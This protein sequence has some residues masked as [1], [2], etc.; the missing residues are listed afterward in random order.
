MAFG[1]K[2]YYGPS[3]RPFGGLPFAARFDEW[4][5]LARI[6]VVDGVFVAAD[7]VGIRIG[8]ADRR[9]RSPQS[10]EIAG[11]LQ[12]AVPH[13]LRHPRQDADTVIVGLGDP[14]DIGS[15]LDADAAGCNGLVADDLDAKGLVT[16]RFRLKQ[17]AALLER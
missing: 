9:E 16:H 5:D 4:G 6:F 8:G 13:A 1:E 17:R 10:L 2:V 12:S 11:E 3:S 7:A 14:V 15:D